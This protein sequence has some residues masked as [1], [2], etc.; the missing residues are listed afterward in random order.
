MNPDF[1]IKPP[2]GIPPRLIRDQ[3]RVDCLIQAIKD[4][5]TAQGLQYITV[6]WA[7]ELIEI[8]THHQSK[9]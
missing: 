2:S 7:E 1:P 4:Y 8:I 3:A 5:N 9:S 6:E